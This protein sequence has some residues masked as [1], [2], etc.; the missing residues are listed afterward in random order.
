MFYSQGSRRKFPSYAFHTK[1]AGIRML[2]AGMACRSLIACKLRQRLRV[3]L[4]EARVFIDEIG[5]PGAVRQSD[6]HG[7]DRR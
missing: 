2:F 5:F 1:N 3:T 4:D 6:G 7:G